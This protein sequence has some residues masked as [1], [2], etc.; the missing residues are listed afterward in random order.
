MWEKKPKT[1][2]HCG[3]LEA[4]WTP[5]LTLL[6]QGVEA[7]EEYTDTRTRATRP[8]HPSFRNGENFTVLK[9]EE[10]QLRVTE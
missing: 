5:Q 7:P 10:S 4:A 2:S 8:A 3:R 1:Q 6:G 9:K